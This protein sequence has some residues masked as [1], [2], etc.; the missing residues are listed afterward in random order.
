M[1]TGELLT[2]QQACQY[3]GISRTTLLK[4]EEEGMLTPSRTVGG[5]RRYRREALDHYLKATTGINKSSD[6]VIKDGQG[7]VMLPGIVGR[8]AL[9]PAPVDDIIKEVLQE[10]VRLLQADAGLVALLDEGGMLYPWLTVGPL[11]PQDTGFSISP[12]D[13]TFSG[14][15]LTLQQPLVYEKERSDIH[16]EGLTQGVCAPLVYR[17]APLGV[18]HVLSLYRHQFLPTEVQFFALVALYMAS[19]IV[20]SQ[21]LADSRRREGELSCLNRLSQAMQGQPDLDGAASVLLEETMRITGADAGI[22]F[23]RDDEGEVGITSLCGLSTGPDHHVASA[24][25]GIAARIIDSGRSY[26]LS[27]TPHGGGVEY[28]PPLLR[29]MRSVILFPLRSQGEQ[30]G[31]LQLFSRNPWN[32]GQ[33]QS[34]LLS[35]VCAQASLVIQRAALCQR[36][37][38]VSEDERA[39]RGYYEKM[40]AASPVAMEIIDKDY[41]IIGWNE[42]AERMTGISREEALGADKFLLQPALLKYDGREILDGVVAHK[43]V[44]KVHRFPYERRDDTVVYTDLTFVPFCDDDGEVTATLVFVQD[45]TELEAL[46]Q[47]IEHT[48]AVWDRQDAVTSF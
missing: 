21:L 32:A 29:D 14:R 23:L 30:L 1:S 47:E 38:Q 36:L 41:R 25:S 11:E 43:E 48:M 17:G 42:A 34:D 22:V 3:L 31:A 39:L 46:R 4:T 12:S 20:N 10:I 9:S 8:L 19:L 40:V 16:L 28:I 33:W 18:I 7:R 27:T 5:H 35:A 37:A 45:I 2:V 26:L 15:V 13:D 44:L 6:S 24:L